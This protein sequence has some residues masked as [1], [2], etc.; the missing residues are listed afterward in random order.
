MAMTR[1]HRVRND[2]LRILGMQRNRLLRYH[3]TDSFV[4]RDMVHVH[5]RLLVELQ[6]RIIPL[7]I[8]R[9]HLNLRFQIFPKIINN[10]FLHKWFLQ[11]NREPGP[12]GPTC[13]VMHM[14]KVSRL[15]S[16]VHAA[17]GLILKVNSCIWLVLNF[18]H[19]MTRSLHTLKIIWRIINRQPR[20]LLLTLKITSLRNLQSFFT[21]IILRN[22]HMLQL[23]WLIQAQLVWLRRVVVFALVIAD[24]IVTR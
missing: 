10:L 2:T 19:K 16:F 14:R 7:L 3:N 17:G 21:V 18:R 1:R 24:G 5:L 4:S 15:S 20:H 13:L 9:R 12:S 6:N 11:L 8:I 22:I 23:N